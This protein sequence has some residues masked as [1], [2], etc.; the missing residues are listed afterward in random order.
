M[1]LL[2]HILYEGIQKQMANNRWTILTRKDS[3]LTHFQLPPYEF[4]LATR[5]ARD[6][7]LSAN[8]LVT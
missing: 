4:D 6:N 7:A 5:Q 8:S 3:M 1:Q 2:V